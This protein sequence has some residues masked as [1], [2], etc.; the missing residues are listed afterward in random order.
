MLEK[1]I[2]K[3]EEIT[4]TTLPAMIYIGQAPDGSPQ[5][6]DVM[7]GKFISTPP[8]SCVIVGRAQVDLTQI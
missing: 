6:L 5:Y 8:V 3:L 2:E 1:R 7:T 4:G